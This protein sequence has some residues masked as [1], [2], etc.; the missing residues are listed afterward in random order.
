[1]WKVIFFRGSRWKDFC[2][3]MLKVELVTAVKC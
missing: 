1:M 3:I 2:W